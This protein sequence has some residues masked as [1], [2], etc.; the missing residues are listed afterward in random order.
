MRLMQNAMNT[1]LGNKI[2]F[3]YMKNHYNNNLNIQS[4]N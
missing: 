1:Q 3:T 2:I 4:N